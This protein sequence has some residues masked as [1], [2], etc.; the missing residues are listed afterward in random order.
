MKRLLAFALAL[1]CVMSLSG[2]G[3]NVDNV[4]IR[5][6]TSRIYTDD[7][8]NNA[9][10]V[11]MDYFKK[12]FDGCTLTEIGYIGDARNEGWQ[13]FADKNQAD[14]VIVLVSSFDVDTSGGDGSLN[15]D[16]TYT[17]WKW[18]LVRSEGGKWEHIDHGY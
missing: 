11:T 4:Y 6:Y 18:I 17:N 7:E 13:E 16:S 8:I 12:E 3:G 10:Q 9:I 14:D 1:L 15:P 5:A 2:C